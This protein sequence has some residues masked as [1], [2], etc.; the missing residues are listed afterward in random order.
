MNDAGRLL[1]TQGSDAT[2]IEGVV[3]ASPDLMAVVGTVK[4][5]SAPAPVEDVVNLE[6]AIVEA[7][8]GGKVVMDGYI[9]FAHPIPVK[10]AT[11]DHVKQASNSVATLDDNGLLDFIE[12]LS[13][14]Q[15]LKDDDCIEKAAACDFVNNWIN[16]VELDKVDGNEVGLTAPVKVAF[17]NERAKEWFLSLFNK[18][19]GVKQAGDSLVERLIE[20]GVNKAAALDKVAAAIVQRKKATA[21]N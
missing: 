16:K 20:A 19:A 2:L 15:T 1:I 17:A 8:Q 5:A 4:E 3:G 10:G 12:K 18:K 14:I 21:T 11:T 7:A 13:H 9:K 6:R